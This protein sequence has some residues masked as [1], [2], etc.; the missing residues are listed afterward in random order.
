M[1]VVTLRIITGRCL[2][3][4]VWVIVHRPACPRKPSRDWINEAEKGRKRAR[5]LHTEALVWLRR[6]R[7]KIV[8]LCVDFCYTDYQPR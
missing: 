1:G 6:R 2:L 4:G 5:Q 7:C 3:T 8:D